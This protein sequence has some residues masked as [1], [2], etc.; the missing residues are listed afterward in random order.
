MEQWHIY[1]IGDG[2]GDED[3]DTDRDVDNRN[4]IVENAELIK[5][6]C[7]VLIF[8]CRLKAKK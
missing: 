1:S 3:G 4:N 7:S 2:D 5:Q 6:I 8:I